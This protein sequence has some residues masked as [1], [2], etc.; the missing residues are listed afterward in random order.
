MFLLQP[1]TETDG[2]IIIFRIAGTL[3]AASIFSLVGGLFI[4]LAVKLVSQ[5][6]IKFGT[7]FWI[8]LV[9]IIF[10]MLITFVIK[11]S[12][13]PISTSL[14]SVLPTIIFFILSWFF[15]SQSVEFG[16]GNDSKNGFKALLTT[17]L[18][19]AFLTVLVIVFVLMTTI[20]KF[21]N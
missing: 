1:N 16:D 11:T 14:G 5:K 20:V 8:S 18:Y 17:F 4:K 10:S 19:M 15:I 7:S 9:T 13:E 12:I 2:V 6:P 3:M 21:N